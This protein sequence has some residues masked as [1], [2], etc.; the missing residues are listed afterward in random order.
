MHA[1]KCKISHIVVVETADPE[2]ENA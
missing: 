2:R 1:I